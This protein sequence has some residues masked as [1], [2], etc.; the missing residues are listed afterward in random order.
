MSFS[1]MALSI[2]RSRHCPASRMPS[3]RNRRA[4]K[5]PDFSASISAASPP[6]A[7]VQGTPGSISA[8]M[9]Q[10]AH[11]EPRDTTA[12]AVSPPA[13]TSAPHAALDQC[14]RRCARARPRAAR[15]RRRGRSRRCTAATLSGG[16]DAAI[17]IGVAPSLPGG[18]SRSRCRASDA[19]SGVVSGS[20]SN[21]GTWS[22]AKPICPSVAREHEP[23]STAAAPAQRRQRARIVSHRQ[24]TGA[25]EILRQTHRHAG[26]AGDQRVRRGCLADRAADARR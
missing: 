24:Q 3:G 17:T 22:R 21:T 18:P 25:A 8:P 9:Q 10:A 23:A 5:L 1:F 19:A 12:P 16:A 20:S 6:S 15:R 4:P 7:K 13:T 2:S 14:R 11:A 26:A